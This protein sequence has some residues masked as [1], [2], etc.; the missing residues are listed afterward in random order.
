MANATV[1][2]VGQIDEA[3]SVTALFLKVFAGEVLTAFATR[4]VFMDKHLVRTISS[5][6]SAQFPT[7]WKGTAGYHTPGTELVGS[8]VAHA[9]RVIAIDDLLVADRFIAKIDEAMNHYDVRSIYSR[10]IGMAL[11]DTFDKH[12]AQVGVLAARAAANMTGANGGTVLTAAGYGT[13]A[14]TLIQGIFDAAKA[15]DQ[16]DVPEQDRYAFLS[17]NLYNL[18]VNSSSSAINRDYN[19]EG[20]GSVASG[21]VFRVA[22]I[23]IIKTNHLPSSNIATGPAAYQGDF[24]TTVALVMQ[25]E[26][27]GTVKLLDLAVEM[28]YDIRRQGTLMV[29]K[30]AVGHGVLRPECAVELKTA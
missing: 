12:V 8:K 9:E 29:G 24:S 21:V 30:Y 1:S 23:P 6:L 22:G 13:T 17:P 27:V 14:A 19:P 16:K 5:G 20:N 15:L 7:S 3:G 25:R 28:A 18:I 4:N 10:D 26:A 11:A 2:R